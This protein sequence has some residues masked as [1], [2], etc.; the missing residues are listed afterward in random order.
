VLPSSIWVTV[1]TFGLPAA[2]I[3]FMVSQYRLIERYGISDEA[4]DPDADQKG[5]P[6]RPPSDDGAA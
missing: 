4:A 5:A 3:A 6:R 1:K 2:M